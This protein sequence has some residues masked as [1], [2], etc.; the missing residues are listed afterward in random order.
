MT[1]CSKT[2]VVGL[3]GGIGC[4]KTLVSSHLMQ[5]GFA[6][7]DADA[8]TREAYEMP[9]VLTSLR[10]AFGEAF[11]GG[12]ID[13]QKL[14]ALVF[15]DPSA[16]ARLNAIMWPA[17]G[18]L[19]REAISRST[20]RTI[21]DAAVLYEAGWQDTVEAVVSVLSPKEVRIERVMSRN[22]LTRDQ[23]LQRMASQANDWHH[24]T[25][26]DACLYNVSTI[27]A[28]LRQTERVFGSSGRGE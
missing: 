25:H 16:R 4:G 20:G 17:L 14:G 2:R 6:I 5:L 28:L 18:N 11:Y 10:Q 12:Q 1:T 13:R 19:A 3:T 15:S 7:V 24:V 22:G 23:V 26:S 8:L 9:S 21:F 27:G